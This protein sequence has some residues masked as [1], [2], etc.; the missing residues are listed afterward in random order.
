MF[1][2]QAINEWDSISLH[3]C[4]VTKIQK[5][6]DLLTFFFDDGFWIIETNP[7]N[8]YKKT[9][10]TSASMLQFKNP[11]QANLSFCKPETNKEKLFAQKNAPLSLDVLIN[12]LD[13]DEWACEIITENHSDWKHGWYYGWFHFKAAPFHIPFELSLSF[14]EV[15]Y[16][17]NE[18][19]ENRPW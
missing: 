8:P 12:R 9:L 11:Q 4:Y 3:D 18:I 5:Q 19:C 13:A 2:Y 14:E 7:Q 10:S 6:D 1:H 17:W 15:R 16:T